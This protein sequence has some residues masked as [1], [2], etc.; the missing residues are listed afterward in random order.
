MTL[1]VFPVAGG[2]QYT[3]DWQFAR[4]GGA[5]AHEGNDLFAPE[6]TPLLA[7]DDG[8]VRYA[9]EGLGGNSVYLR[10]DD[11]V[12]YFYTHLQSFEGQ[13]R[14]VQAG[15]VIGYLG[16]T[17]NAR[18]TA[19]HVHFGVYRGGAPEN[20]FPLLQRASIQNAPGAG[21]RGIS[22]FWTALALTGV[23][24]GVWAYL[25]PSGARALLRR[26]T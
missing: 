8:T 25:N 2:A 18:T 16:K 6:G 15:E 3:N 12:T 19:P 20:P 4:D 26:Y 14:R 9:V 24:L 13:A 23:G 17:G 11:G 10:A 22:L 7:V 5:R 21:A 1:R